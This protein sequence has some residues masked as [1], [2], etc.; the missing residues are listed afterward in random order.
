MQKVLLGVTETASRGASLGAQQTEPCKEAPGV[1]AVQFAALALGGGLGETGGVSHK[2]RCRFQE[3]KARRPLGSGLGGRGCPC[4]GAHGCSGPG[5]G[6]SS[7]RRR[8]RRGSQAAG[9]SDGTQHGA[10][11]KCDPPSTRPVS[12]ERAGFSGGHG[13]RPGRPE[14]SQE[15]LRRASATS[16]HHPRES[17][18]QTRRRR[19]RL[20]WLLC[21]RRVSVSRVGPGDGTRWDRPDSE[22]GLQ[23]PRPLRERLVR[24]QLCQVTSEVAGTGGSCASSHP[25]TPAPGVD[26]GRCKDPRHCWEQSRDWSEVPVQPTQHER[27]LRP[28]RV[29]AAGFSRVGTM[30]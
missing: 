25:G 21:R 2:P 26:R 15:T 28:E 24:R 18:L 17:R 19:C 16:G 8:S 11:P 10:V 22:G 23:G 12:R 27:L 3:S 1:L 13:G 6:L 14:R 20:S 30:L 9:W 4:L 5:G 7:R 29:K